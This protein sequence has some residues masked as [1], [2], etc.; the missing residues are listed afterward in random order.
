MNAPAGEPMALRRI[1]EAMARLSGNQA[2]PLSPL[3]RAHELL[4][5]C[6]ADD[7]LNGARCQIRAVID[8]LSQPRLANWLR[9]DGEA[10][11][12]LAIE[13]PSAVSTD[14][15]G[16]ERLTGRPFW[17]IPTP[18]NAAGHGVARKGERQAEARARRQ[19]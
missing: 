12:W 11:D 19:R 4:F 18:R 15:Q 16:L 14:G 3:R 10:Q 17:A 7:D 9:D 5:F 13:L 6:S 8:G 2:D 1:S